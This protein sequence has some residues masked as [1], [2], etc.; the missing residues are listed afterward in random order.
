MCKRINTG[1]RASHTH[2]VNLP[3]DARADAIEI[4]A[5]N[6]K[7]HHTSARQVTHNT[8]G[9][10]ATLDWVIVSSQRRDRFGVTHVVPLCAT[11]VDACNT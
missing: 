5:Q 6:A 7:T 1:D 2:L 10:S 8:H 4:P 3:C 11:H 9:I